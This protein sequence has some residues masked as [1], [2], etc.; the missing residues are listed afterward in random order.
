MTKQNRGSAKSGFR[1]FFFRGLGI[2]LPSVLTIWI[3]FVAYQFVQ[4]RIAGPINEGIK[5][6]VVLTPLLSVNEQERAEAEAA[7]TS[8]ERVAW[9]NAGGLGAWLDRHVRKQKLARWW[10]DYGFALDLIG[11]VVAVL[12]IYIVGAA[13]G[14]IIGKRLYAGGERLISRVPLIKQVYPSVKQ[15][16]EFLVGPSDEVEKMRF[17]RVVAVEYPRKGLWSVGLVTGS[18]MRMI[19]ERAGTPSLTVFI[20]SS[21]T[22]FTGYVITVPKEDT[23]D[24]PVTIEEALR[25]S[26]SAGVIV[27]PSQLTKTYEDAALTSASQSIGREPA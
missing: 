24:L 19:Q 8:E 5:K 9:R 14:S 23:I 12:L 7:L 2:L 10:E 17:S 1:K 3:L 15:V 16:T 20:P 13:L 6:V 26:V 22:P 18:T 4:T 25:F 11:L 27:P 21:P